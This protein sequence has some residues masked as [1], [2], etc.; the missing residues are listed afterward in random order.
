ELGGVSPDG[1]TVV[2]LGGGEPPLCRSTPDASKERLVRLGIDRP[3]ALNV[4]RVESRKNQVT[5]LRAIERLADLLLVCAGPVA[6]TKVAAQLQSPCCRMLGPV[7]E[8]DLDLLYN[9]AEALVFPSLYEGFGLPVLEAMRRGLPGGT[10]AVS[11][12]PEVG[13]DGAGSAGDPSGAGALAPARSRAWGGAFATRRRWRGSGGA[14]RRPR[15]AAGPGRRP[16][17]PA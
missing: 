2:R 10:A 1:L 8:G 17:W 14:V 7:A 11:S 9:C 13:G 12:P 6:D 15:S 4:G 5:A 3:F 16:A